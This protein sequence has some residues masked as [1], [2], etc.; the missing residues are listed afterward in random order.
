MANFK[1]IMALCV[2]GKSYGQIAAALG[3]SRRD[4]SRVQAII[5]DRGIDKERFESLSPQWF[6]DVFDDGR[7][8]RSKAYD[9]P[10]FAAMAKRLGHNKHLTRHKLWLDYI[11]TECAPGLE[12]YQYSQFCHHFSGFIRANDLRDVI[13]H[14]PGQELYVDWAGDK[15][16]IID[17]ASGHVALKASL[18]LA[19]C[20]YSGLLFATAAENEKMPAWLECHVKALNYL[21]K[22]PAIIVPDNASTATYR[23][24]R[25]QSYRAVTARYADFADFYDLVIVPTRPGKPKDKAAV[26]RAVQIAYSRILGYF[27]GEV[28]YSLDELNEAIADRVEDINCVLTRAD[29]TTRRQRFDTHEAPVMRE[30]PAQAFTEV[31]WRS[32]K[33]DRNWH[34]CCDYQYYSVPYELVGKVLRARLTTTTVSLFDGDELVAEHDRHHGFRYRYSTNHAHGPQGSDDTVDVLTRDELLKWASSFGPNTVKVITTIVDNNAASIPRG[35]SLA[36][37][38]LANL[39]RRHD[40]TSL[41]PACAVVVGK[42]LA[43]NFAVIKRIQADIGHNRQA[44]PQQSPAS[45]YPQVVD[46][47]NMKDAVFIRPASHFN[48]VEW[49]EA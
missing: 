24:K 32:P 35:L 30:L 5:R 40:K 25:H 31:V 43:A 15:I 13:E 27:D 47:T 3:C 9:Q 39:G 46:I 8:S 22:L 4:I 23:P 18:F 7:A 37:N 11:S 12:K 38:V 36:R 26:E 33:V 17:Q 1:E 21:G 41:E 29:G 44:V 20:P 42:K 45:S 48:D 2:E 34:V 10:D 28:F 14:A 49:E 19:V 16:A 6:A